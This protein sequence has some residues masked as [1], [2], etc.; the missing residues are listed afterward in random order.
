MVMHLTEN[1]SQLQD[2]LDGRLADQEAQAVE[3]HLSECPQCQA[4]FQQW[5]Q[6]DSDLAS[7]ITAPQLSPDFFSG[8]HARIELSL[9]GKQVTENEQRRLD[10][11][12]RATWT[13][14]RKN[15]IRAQMPLFLDTLGYS[16]AGAVA[17]YFL[18]KLILNVLN[19]PLQSLHLSSSQLTLA[20]AV[21]AACVFLLAGF[22]VAVR[23][24]LL[25][26]MEA[27]SA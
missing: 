27:L 21:A 11:D 4:F 6:L 2:Y 26:F 20:V 1:E 15:F 13:A 16:T 25:G 17:A 14:L 24:Q 8:L 19:T 9:P 3:A 12:D 18:F 22:G 7:S 23:K 10:S 5:E